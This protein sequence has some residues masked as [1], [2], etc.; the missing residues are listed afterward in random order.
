MPRCRKSQVESVCCRL[1]IT[2]VFALSA[3]VFVEAGEPASFASPI[4]DTPFRQVTSVKYVNKPDLAGAKFKKMVIDYR[5]NVFVLTDKGVYRNFSGERFGGNFLA[6]DYSYASL[7]EKI[8]VDITIQSETGYLYYLYQDGFLT[9]AHAG[10]IYAHFETQKYTNILVNNE[11]TILLVGDN[12]AALYQRNEKR[13]D[14]TPPPADTCQLLCFGKE[15]YALTP[16]QLMRL[17]ESSWETVFSGEPMSCAAVEKD[18]FIIGTE[19][20]VF[21]THL[22][23]EMIKPLNNRIPIPAV[24]CALL[25]NGKCW[26]GSQQG[27]FVEEPD[28]WRYYAGPRWLDSDLVLDIKSDSKGN[29]FVL[30]NSGLNEIRY[31]EMT[32][33]KK[34]AMIQEEIEKYH[35]RF[36]WSSAA[37]L[38]D[39]NDPTTISLRDSDNDGLWTSIYLGSQAFRYAVTQDE[40]ARRNVWEAFEAFERNVAIHGLDG[41][42]ART[43]ERKG[44]IDSD[45]DAWRSSPESDWDWK[46]TTST[47]E[48]VGY[49]FV[50]DLIDRLV[51]KTPEEK[52]RV[53]DYYDAI[54]SHVV[55]NHYYMIDYDG[56]PTLWARWNAEYVNSFNTTQFDRKLNSVLITAMLQLGYRLTGKELYK[57]EMERLWTEWGYW[58]NMTRPMSEIKYTEGFQH[59]GI[60]MGLDWNHSD[61]EMAFMTYYVL[62]HSMLDETVRT[63]YEK[64]VAEHWELEKPEKNGLW[65]ILS[66]SCCG[67]ID[68]DAAIWWLR[69][70]NLDR[71]DWKVTNSHR[72]DLNYRSREYKDNFRMQMTDELLTQGELRTM[73]HNAN[74]FV[75][76]GGGDGGHLLTGEEYLLPYWMCRYY[77]VIENQK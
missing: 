55:R 64:I 58:E 31:E 72:N 42:S 69:E 73:R 62:L 66:F 22:N 8:P 59:Q 6:K 63:D 29:I 70:Y 49:I 65:N 53:A 7:A 39:P 34:A 30:S 75:L 21:E 48:V 2:A 40:S 44:F 47:D 60:T 67:K 16:T 56:N 1:M 15:F 36:G 35:N 5:D 13:A 12:A 68:S 14:L 26:Y 51:A 17:N 20:G 24:T 32:L 9:N 52:Q 77:G 3:F 43:F 25:S 27:V 76:D 10:T 11:E 4:A 50:T 19:N 57:N 23:G 37:K 74:A 18:R 45:P 38:I 71:R 54:L 41:F 46:G 61:D 28:R 33:S